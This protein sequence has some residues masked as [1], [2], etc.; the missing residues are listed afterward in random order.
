[1]VDGPW[2]SCGMINQE[3]FHPTMSSRCLPSWG[4]HTI[5]ET[6][7]LYAAPECPLIWRLHHSYIGIWSPS[8]PDAARILPDEESSHHVTARRLHATRSP[9]C[10]VLYD[11]Q[12]ASHS[13]LLSA[14]TM[15][16]CS[17]RPDAWAATPAATPQTR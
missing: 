3:T 17:Q 5:F 12:H 11:L 8:S 10:F 1:M 2:P 9:D 15:V 16:A 4:N 7:S 6:P 13:E 14:A